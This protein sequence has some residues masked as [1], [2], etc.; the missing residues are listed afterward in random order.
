MSTAKE[1]LQQGRNPE[2]PFT[3]GEIKLV[4]RV[5]YFPLSEPSQDPDKEMQRRIVTGV[6]ELDVSDWRALNEFATNYFE[7]LTDPDNMTH[8]TGVPDSVEELK[9]NLKAKGRH[10]LAIFNI[11]GE[12]VGFA[13]IDDPAKDELDGRLGKFGI[14]KD[15]Q[16][17]KPSNGEK[18]GDGEQRPKG[19]GKQALGKVL[20]W[21]FSNPTHDGKERVRI[22]AYIMFAADEGKISIEG[23]NRMYRILIAAG[24]EV[25]GLNQETALAY[26]KGET[27]KV[28]GDSMRMKLLKE[29]WEKNKYKFVS[30]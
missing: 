6:K 15:L 18:A 28:I 19:V 25:I 10:S 21:A 30:N 4:H 14:I 23:W 11:L 24:A 3:T 8:F 20:E 17:T 27:E 5:P 13:M 29:N 26:Q 12:V 7:L 9:E 1:S 2:I 22:D 16:N